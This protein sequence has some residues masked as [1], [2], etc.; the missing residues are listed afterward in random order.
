MSLAT[1]EEVWAAVSSNAKVRA[2]L[3]QTSSD[4]ALNEGPPRGAV[5]GSTEE[6]QSRHSLQEIF[7][8]V[9]AK[10]GELADYLGSTLATL[11]GFSAP[12]EDGPDAVD[13][14]GSGNYE[15]LGPEG[16]RRLGTIVCMAIL[17]VFG[18]LVKRVRMGWT[19]H[20]AT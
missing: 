15:G 17:L 6:E 4:L 20:V 11:F 2:I 9:A 18:L 1:D 5:E 14:C 10:A 13:P 8:M 16:K 7:K 19:A 12:S 3:A